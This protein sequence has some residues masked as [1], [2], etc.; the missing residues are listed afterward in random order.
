[1]SALHPAVAESTTRETLA[2]PSIV[3][4]QNLEPP[5][6]PL[7]SDGPAARDG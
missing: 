2:T 7:G 4:S 5:V 1:M 3:T 6:P